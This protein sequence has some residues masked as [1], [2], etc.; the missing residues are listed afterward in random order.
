[1]TGTAV[2][3][4]RMPGQ[5]PLCRAGCDVWLALDDDGEPR[6]EWVTCGNCLR[7][8]RTDSKT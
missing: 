5:T 8:L 4:P 3:Y 1:V 6:A 7:M 2:H